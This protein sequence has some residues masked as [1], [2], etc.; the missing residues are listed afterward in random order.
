MD[1][2]SGFT[3]SATLIL[4]ARGFDSKLLGELREEAEEIWYEGEKI[5]LKSSK[6]HDESGV[7]FRFLKDSTAYD[8]LEQMEYSLINFCSRLLSQRESWR[9][10]VP[11]LS[12]YI[13]TD[14]NSYPPI[15]FSS[16]ILKCLVSIDAEMDIDVI[17]AL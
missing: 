7:E 10:V 11:H 13:R 5:S 14:G 2:S 17:A 6:T 4:S 8:W 15:F 12:I 3:I 16:G 9:G 1:T